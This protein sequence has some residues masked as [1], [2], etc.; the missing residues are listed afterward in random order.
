MVKKLPILI[1]VLG[2]L[3]GPLGA[4]PPNAVKLPGRDSDT[5]VRQGEHHA[6]GLEV[7][8]KFRKHPQKKTY[9]GYNP[10]NSSLSH[11]R[12]ISG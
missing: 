1:I 10:I 8:V 2:I 9:I 7:V 3:M 12:S 5:P 11:S 6:V 4:K